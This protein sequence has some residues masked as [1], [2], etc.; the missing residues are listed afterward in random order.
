MTATT[1]AMRIHSLPSLRRFGEEIEFA[2]R[3]RT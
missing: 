2:I 1:A 3:G